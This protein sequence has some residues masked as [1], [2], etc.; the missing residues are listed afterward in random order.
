VVQVIYCRGAA[1]GWSA[2]DRLAAL[3][4]DFFDSPV[5]TLQPG[6]AARLKGAALS[7]LPRPRSSEAYLFIAA[8]PQHLAAVGDLG[9]IVGR[10]GHVCAW[11]IDSFWT[12]RLPPTI[13]WSRPVDSFYITDAE[14][15]GHYRR[16]TRRPVHWLPW[17]ADVVGMPDAS[18]PRPVDV[19]R[20]GRQPVQWEDDESIGTLMAARD[21]AYRGRPPLFEDPVRNQAEVVDAVS[22]AKFVVA[23]GNISAPDLY[24]HPRHE[25]LTGRWT[26]ALAAGASVVG[27]PPNC[28]ATRELLWPEGLVTLPTTD[29]RGNLDLVTE[30]VAGWSPAQAVRNQRLALARLDWRR[31][32]LRVARDLGVSPAGADRARAVL[33]GR[34]A[35][36]G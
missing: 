9:S 18:G 2:I 25:Y 21:L 28:V 24:T 34:L 6:R 13:A 29:M 35:S 23:F 17:G 27:I 33:S 8:Q 10:R 7:L 15:V 14:L 1:L 30:A 4:G 19:L 36:A 22:G 32:L 11:V 5:L 26:E 20:L 31:R 12:E 16:A 3:A